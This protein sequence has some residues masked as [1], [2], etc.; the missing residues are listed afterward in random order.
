M[1]GVAAVLLSIAWLGC[2]VSK[3]DQ[4]D[5]M[6]VH[7]DEHV[8]SSFRLV[9]VAEAVGVSAT[10]T[11][12]SDGDLYLP[13]IMGGG[14]AV[15]DVDNDGDLDLFLVQAGVLSGDAV[16]EDSTLRQ[17]RLYVNNLSASGV[18]E[19]TVVPAARTQ[20]AR[21][22]GD[23]Y[24]M[25][26]ATGD[27]DNDGW[28]DIYVTAL[29]PNRLL[30]NRGDG[31]FE[32]VGQIAGV[33]GSEWSVSATVADLNNDG[34]L[35]LFVGNYLLWKRESYRPCYQAAGG[36]DYCG[37]DSFR[38]ESNEVYLNSGDG[39]F[40]R[41]SEDWGFQSHEA[42]PT[43]GTIAFDA[44]GDGD[45]DLYEANDGRA[46]R[47]WINHGGWFEESA[48]LAGCAVN[49]EGFPEAS[50]GLDAADID[51]DGD[52]DL[53]ITHLTGESHTLYRNDGRGLFSDRSLPSGLGASSLNATGFGVVLSD[54]DGDGWHDLLVANGAVRA[55]REV[56]T[57]LNPLPLEQPNQFLSGHVG[58]GFDDASAKL[59]ADVRTSTVSRG[60]AAG[61]LDND[62]DLDAVVINIGAAAQVLVNQSQPTSDAWVGVRLVTGEGKRDALGAR[63]EV[64]VDGVRIYVGRSYTDGSYAS[65][66]DPRVLVGL[67]LLRSQTVSVRVT[68]LNGTMEQWSELSTG[69]YHTLVSGTGQPAS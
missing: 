37:P 68:D 63:V 48:Q 69:R 39:T 56:A 45:V 21:G 42:A 9:D 58:G 55:I 5:R 23:G 25:G 19:F 10:Y 66:R 12:T 52:V 2:N 60:I 35:D 34:W 54:F 13:R 28:M 14:G 27:F 59:G 4:S 31:S 32:D 41:V 38:A 6:S 36:L 1:P 18:L 16:A 50:M 46:N 53:L 40:E 64:F 15:L 49:G 11:S 8:S 47:L 30:R 57:L 26:A 67:G 51:Q 7:G 44:D 61:D 17:D 29:G 24:G 65:A 22:V 43:L 62:G 33:A 3:R 20:F